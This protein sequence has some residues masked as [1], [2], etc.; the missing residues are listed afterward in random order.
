[1]KSSASFLLLLTVAF[2][3][4]ATARAAGAKEFDANLKPFLAK[5]CLE[6]H[7]AETTKGD[8]RLDNL[9]L[10]LNDHTN[11]VTWEKVF[12]K[13]TRGEMPPKKKERP[14]QNELR[15]AMDWLRVN[16]HQASAARQAAEGRVVFRRLNRVEYENT[17][18]DLLAIETPLKDLLPEDNAAHG[19]DNIGAALDTSS[20]LMERYLEAADAAI[21]TA[22]ARGVK[23]TIRTERL[24][25]LDDEQLVNQLDGKTV[26]KRADG[27]VMLSSGY[28][29]TQLR[30]FRAPADGHYRVRVSAC[31]Y[32]SEKPVVMVAI[33][34]DINTGRGE[35]HY[36][37]FFDAPPGKPVVFEFTDRLARGNTFKV[38]PFRLEAGEMARQVGAE[39]YKGPGLVVQWVEV[40]GPLG[41]TWPPESRARLFGN[42][43]VEPADAE[44]ARTLAR[45]QEDPRRAEYQLRSVKWGVKS[46]QPDADAERLLRDF[47]P[48]AFRRPVTDAEIAPFVVLVKARLKQGYPFD[49]AMRVGF[50][51]VL[52]S[53]EFLFLKEKSGKLD[54][55]ALVSRLSYFLW[56]APPDAELL[57]LAKQGALGKPATLRAQTERMLK[58]PKS[59][60]FT[61]NFLGQ[62][63]ELRQI[64]FT[65]PDKKLYPEFDELLKRSMV[66]E[67]E[68]FF[69]ELLA[70]DLSVQN[71]IHSDFT[72]L[73]E[74]LAEH[75][76]IAGV[77]GQEF[78]KVSLAPGS[79]R[80]GVITHASVLKVTANGTTT[81][82][83]LR[84]KWVLDRI[85]GVPPDPPPKNVGAVEP[86]IRGTKTIR[87]QLDA[88]RNIEACATCHRK[89]DPPGFALENFD[90]IG[91]W[92]ERYRT[93][94][95][96]GSRADLV[97]VVGAQG[98]RHVA[99]GQK[100]DASFTTAEGQPFKDVDEFK[101]LL[102]RDKEQIARCVTE[103]LLVYATGA[104]IQ[105]AD[106][107]A[108]DGVVGK[109][110]SKNYGLRSI[111]HEVVQSQVFLNK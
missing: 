77:T 56:S 6:C 73:N 51:A 107:A 32:Q 39:N 4:A 3:G 5:H 90:V 21:D 72:M 80:G 108:V 46:A 24:S 41:E 12:D 83:V 111:V 16:L 93:M 87:E 88:H 43:P 62:W 49:E 102:L 48:R 34:G 29:P 13:V 57:A 2:S 70:R 78:Q 89:I 55:Y 17:L 31:A 14:P 74:R 110:K 105:F 23:P 35:S 38:M 7:D 67:T 91:G 66:R 106:R 11:F 58:S 30:R 22:M 9:A 69:E 71:F 37:G 84:G 54:D 86:D 109:V 1:M 76:G 47:A 79:H 64:D 8:L 65:S 20:V 26:L 92:R 42:L 60:G 45:A 75:Y 44:S 18:H 98:N 25:Y 36:I 96:R 104:G 99:L 53:P 61:E 100:V 81:S 97:R 52:T 68:L 82:P 85:M 94:P 95:E 19:F 103:K 63:L 50:K 15:P 59:R 10:T 101:K 33:G 28:M 27:I 40:E